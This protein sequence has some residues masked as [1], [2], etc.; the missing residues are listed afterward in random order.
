MTT[1]SQARAVP[2]G[3]SG[4]RISAWR[5]AH[6]LARLAGRLRAQVRE[7]AEAGQLGPDPETEIGRWTGARV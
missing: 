3:R 2:L 6:A 1:V 7:L 5:L 4:P